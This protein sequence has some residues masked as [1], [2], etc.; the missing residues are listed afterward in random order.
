MDLTLYDSKGRPTAYSEDGVHIYT[1]SGLPVAYVSDGSVYSMEGKHLGWFAK[2]WLRDNKGRCVFF[3][4]IAE[5][6]GPMTPM[7]AMKPMKSLKQIGPVKKDREPKPARP[8]ESMSWS[9][10]SGAQFFEQ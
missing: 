10:L 7:T 4:D 1:F 8:V 3:T 6:S 9:E 2:G 5:G